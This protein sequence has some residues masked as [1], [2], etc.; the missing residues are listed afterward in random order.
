MM[1]ILLALNGN[2]YMHYIN[3]ATLRAYI[4]DGLAVVEELLTLDSNYY[5]E[6]TPVVGGN[7]VSFTADK[8]IYPSSIPVLFEKY[9]LTIVSIPD[10]ITNSIPTYDYDNEYFKYLL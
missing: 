1:T 8:L 4:T 10:S 9:Y 7:L 2:F 6:L 3:L 5:M